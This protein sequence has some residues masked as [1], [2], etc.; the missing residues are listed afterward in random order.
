MLFE[1]YCAFTSFL[2]AILTACA[3]QNLF[4]AAL[5]IKSGLRANKKLHFS[6]CQIETL[7]PQLEPHSRFDSQQFE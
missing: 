6:L 3:A 1:K 4:T 2:R 5:Q 7:K